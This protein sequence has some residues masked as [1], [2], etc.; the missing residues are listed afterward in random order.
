MSDGCLPPF[1]VSDVQGAVWPPI[2]IGPA[3]NLA[4]LVLQLERT[5]R[6][7]RAEILAGQE[8]QLRALIT[9]A[10]AQ[11]PHFQERLKAARLKPSHI[12]SLDDLRRL[13]VLK[14]ADIQAA[15]Q[16]FFCRTLPPNHQL[17]GETKTSGSTGEP[18]VTR[19]TAI[20]QLYY[21]AHS[22]RNHA[23]HN[24]DMKGRLSNV[25]A[26]ITSFQISEEWGVPVSKLYKTGELMNMPVNSDIAEQSRRLAEFQ[27]QILL[28]YPTAL[29]GLVEHW[30][31]EGMPL[32]DLRHIK[33]I[34]ET[35]SDHL[36][37]RVKAVTGLDIEDH[38]SSQEMGCIAMQCKEGGLYHVMSENIIVEVLDADGEPCREGEIGRVVVTELQNL[39]SPMIRYDIGDYAEV[40]GA[41]TCGRTLPT[42]KRILG[43]ER[44]LVRHP[45]G[46]RNWPVVGFHHYEKVAPLRQYQFVQTSLYD[47]EFRV[48]SDE[49][50]SEEQEAGLAAILRRSLGEE[51]RIKVIQSRERL[52]VGPGGKFEEFMCLVKD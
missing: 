10:A 24:R 49:P 45:D 33:T 18:V 22:L 37:E 41:C 34:G 16:A 35:V 3:A 38:Y 44:N 4:A 9:H 13:P 1:E 26:N 14:R 50:L 15:G 23:W 6:L 51:F 46:R 48:V 25:R 28:I 52:A 27:P 20:T 30:A 31:Q 32:H 11:S 7:P 17:L 42:L 39:A 8:R 40:G 36:R 12:A 2:L 21:L 47:I 19:K 29:G 5:E 43:R